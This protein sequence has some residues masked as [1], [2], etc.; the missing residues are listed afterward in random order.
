MF[1]KA[2]EIIKR[3][4]KKMPAPIV[5][6]NKQTIDF[7][8]YKYPINELRVP[9]GELLDNMAVCEYSHYNMGKIGSY[10][11][12]VIGKKFPERKFALRK[13]KVKNKERVVVYR[14]K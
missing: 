2:N 7:S 12:T 11:R 10:V 3:G 9:K 14:I 5:V 1:D 6:Q 4:Y 8:G 13:Q